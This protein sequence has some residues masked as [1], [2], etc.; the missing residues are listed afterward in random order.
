MKK[1]LSFILLAALCL[2]LCACGQAP[3]PEETA[4][5]P[6]D[7]AVAEEREEQAPAS[8][9]EQE[10][11]T[12]ASVMPTKDDFEIKSMGQ[13]RNNYGSLISFVSVKNR[14]DALAF[15][16]VTASYSPLGSHDVLGTSDSITCLCPGETR[17]MKFYYNPNLS[18]GESTVVSVDYEISEISLAQ[19]GW[20]PVLESLSVEECHVSHGYGDRIVLKITNN[21]DAVASAVWV[22]ALSGPEDYRS[23]S[24]YGLSD[25]LPGESAYCEITVDPDSEYVLYYGGYSLPG[26]KGLETLSEDQYELLVRD[27]DLF[28]WHLVITNR[29][30]RWLV[31]YADPWAVNDAGEVFALLEQAVSAPVAPGE[32]C[33]L[34][35]SYRD[36]FCDPEEADHIEFNIR[37]EAADA[38]TLSDLVEVESAR[39]G[40]EIR[41]TATNNAQQKV[42]VDVSVLYV[43]ASG[44]LVG[45]DGA[46]FYL[47][48]GETEEDT[49]K[50]WGDA[51]F[52]DYEIYTE[53][54][55][56]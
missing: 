47:D 38:S 9:I 36:I 51:D 28:S 50:P 16:R 12:P 35:C 27:I 37:A 32:S 34:S 29:S 18:P 22:D 21:G 24:E 7:N 43:D 30:D 13:E 40:D 25:L 8:A 3:A 23:L 39:S 19:D 14:S 45:F 15:I 20:I 5:S 33:L 56:R 1:L 11:Q 52:K 46:T 42:R 49:V 55:D 31:F 4:E 44:K 41:L 6:A 17:F 54:S 48:G 2:S 26:V 10:M 53:V